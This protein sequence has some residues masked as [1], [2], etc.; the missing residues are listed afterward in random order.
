M[1]RLSRVCLGANSYKRSLRAKWG[2]S[3]EMGT[4][5]QTLF[6]RHFGVMLLADSNNRNM[7]YRTSLFYEITYFCL[8][9]NHYMEAVSVRYFCYY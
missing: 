2:L 5:P 7:N 9:L 6:S 4:K 1:T 3:A 8:S